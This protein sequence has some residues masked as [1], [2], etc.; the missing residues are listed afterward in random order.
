MV[1]NL[2]L[3]PRNCGS[4][5]GEVRRAVVVHEEHILAIAAAL[6]DVEGASRHGDPRNPWHPAVLRIALR[7]VEQK[8]G[9]VN[10]SMSAILAI[11]L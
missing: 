1:R 6:R 8:S 11:D 4:K 7:R 2:G 5:Q 3:C 9:T 10:P